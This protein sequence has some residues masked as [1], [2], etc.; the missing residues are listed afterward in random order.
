MLKV[1]KYL[2]M[3]ILICF[4]VMMLSSCGVVWIRPISIAKIKSSGSRYNEQEVI[5][6]GL[7]SEHITEIS[8][9]ADYDGSYRIDDGSGSIIIL[10]KGMPPIKMTTEAVRGIVKKVTINGVEDKAIQKLEIK[11]TVGTFGNTLDWIIAAIVLIAG[12]L[13][14]IYVYAIALYQMNLYSKGPDGARTISNTASALALFA[15]IV[16]IPIVLYRGYSYIPFALYGLYFLV[17]FIILIV[18]YAKPSR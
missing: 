6:Q 17:A 9:I 16:M 5:V 11:N 15:L 12:I 4:V 2:V 8:D 13:V 1:S 14:V 3:A 10:A 7:V 18:Y